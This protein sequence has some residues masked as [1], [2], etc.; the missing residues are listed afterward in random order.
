MTLRH[1]RNDAAPP[2]AP[3][4]AHMSA[5]GL[6]AAMLALVLALLPLPSSRAADATVVLT[7]KVS[8]GGDDLRGGNVS[9]TGN[10]LHIALLD[11][12]GR[13]LVSERNA[14]RSQTWG[15]NSSHTFTLRHEGT[16]GSL[17]HVELGVTDR[18]KADIF[19]A[20]DQW[21]FD[22]MRITARVAGQERVLYDGQPRRT[23]VAGQPPIRLPLRRFVDQCAS[24]AACSDGRRCNGEESCVWVGT[25]DVLR[26]CRPGRP[27]LC[28]AGIACREEGPQ[29]QAPPQ[30]RDGDGAVA[31]ASGGDDCDDND[32]RRF[33]GNAEVC[34]ADGVDEDCDLTTGGQRDADRDG[35]ND[36]ACFNWG[37]PPRR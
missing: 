6:A 34:D 16:L 32:P 26:Q 13:P 22:A 25:G 2:V 27:V 30:D 36:A 11:E 3:P 1:A 20:T 35:Y 24:D 29:C 8:T 10:N 18:M 28:P 15:G 21:S 37:P 14:N 33:P 31:I 12:R 9:G 4:P 5:Q 17:A 23:L 19:E 7:V